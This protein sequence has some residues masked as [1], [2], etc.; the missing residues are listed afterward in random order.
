MTIQA[1]IPVRIIIAAQ[2][3]TIAAVRSY[4]GAPRAK[5]S[6]ATSN[7]QRSEPAWLTTILA[8]IAVLHFGAVLAYLISPSFLQW[9]A[10]GSATVTRW[11]GIALSC[12]GIAG[13]VWA[14]VALGASYSPRLQVAD[15]RVVV[16]AGPYRWIRHPLYAFWL[17][18]AV[19]WGLAACDWFILFSGVVLIFVLA[20]A[21]VPREEAMMLRGFGERYRQYM[22]RTGRF[23]PRLRIL[24]SSAE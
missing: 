9:S 15:E 5:E 16:I 10:F 24:I 12:L 3:I 18:T 19:G 13:E 4:F 2:L 23:I 1:D 6:A 11:I 20:V 22:S 21:R 14:A 8:M 17:P 7:A